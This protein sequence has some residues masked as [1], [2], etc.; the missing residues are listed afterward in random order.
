MSHGGMG[1]AREYDV[2]RY[3][4]EIFVPRIAPVSRE[5]IKNYISTQV[6]RLPRSY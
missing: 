1:Y 2:E 5:M 3:L 4:R 6:L